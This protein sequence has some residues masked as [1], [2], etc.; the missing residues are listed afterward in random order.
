MAAPSTASA[1]EHPVEAMIV[2]RVTAAFS[3]IHLEVVNES[4]KH[5]VPT[6]SETHFKVT[7]I[8]FAHGDIAEHSLIIL[9]DAVV[10]GFRSF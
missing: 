1:V 10:S 2:E 4:Y 7:C 6:G 3:P 5:S 9:C 8:S